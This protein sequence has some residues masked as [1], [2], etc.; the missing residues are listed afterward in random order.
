[1]GLCLLSLLNI[2][3][4]PSVVVRPVLCV[5][6]GKDQTMRFHGRTSAMGEPQQ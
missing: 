2:P 3:E 6:A 1:M 4:A 5:L